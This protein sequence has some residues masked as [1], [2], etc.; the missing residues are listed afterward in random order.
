MSQEFL[1]DW[2]KVGTELVERGNRGAYGKIFKIAKVH[3]TGR[4]TIDEPE[5][6]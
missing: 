6:F 1:P 3:K 5:T 2:V 4:F